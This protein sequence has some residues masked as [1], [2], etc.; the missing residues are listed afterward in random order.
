MENK[1]VKNAQSHVYEN[2]KFVSGLEVE[3]YKQ[4]KKAGLDPKYEPCTFHLLEGKKFSIPCYD[5]HNDRKLKKDVWGLNTYKTQAIKYTP[6]FVFYVTTSSGAERMVVVESKGYPNDRWGYVKK[7]FLTHLENYYPE[8]MF[9]EVHN[10]KQLKAA[11]EVI[12][13][14]K[15]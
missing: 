3:T 1:K 15:Q 6:D 5:L 10:Q 4:L 14:I 11:I 12:K 2:I 7:M 8:S 9:F 13:S